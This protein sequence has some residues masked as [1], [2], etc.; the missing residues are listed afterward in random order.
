MQAFSGLSMGS[1]YKPPRPQATRRTLQGTLRSL[2]NVE[3]CERARGPLA[4]DGNADSIKVGRDVEY[5]G[6][7]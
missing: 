5:I 1:R 4:F 7:G 3:E 6:G 2:Y